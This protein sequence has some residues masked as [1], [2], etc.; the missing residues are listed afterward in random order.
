M[1]ANLLLTSMPLRSFEGK[2]VPWTD[3]ETALT[4]LDR[5]EPGRTV[6]ADFDETLFLRNSS[7]EFI[8][9]VKPYLFGVVLFKILEFLRPWSWF[10]RPRQ[11]VLTRDWFHV[12][13]VTLFFPWTWLLWRKNARKMADVWT[14]K[15]LLEVLARRDPGNVVICSQ[16]FGPVVRPVLRHMGLGACKVDTCGLLTGYRDR[17]RPKTRRVA[18]LAGE[19][20]LRKAAVVTDSADD[21]DILEAAGVPLLVEWP[22]SPII[23]VT[24][25]YIPFYYMV[26][27]K[28]KGLAPIVRET[29]SVDL[30]FLLLA[31]S[32]ISPLPL[33][34]AF[35]LFLFFIS[36][37]LVYE[38]GYMENDQIAHEH[39]KDPVFGDTFKE[40]INRINYREP[41]IWAAF[42]TVAG[43]SV[44]QK[45]HVLHGMGKTAPDLFGD[46]TLVL[47]TY[48]GLFL[49]QPHV[50]MAIIWMLVLVCLR[51]VYTAY[52]HTDKMTRTWIY[53]VLQA[54][55]TV[56]FMVIS[57]TN[58]V[59]VIALCSQAA[60]RSF[61]YFLYRWSKYD[62]PG[63]ELHVARL[64]LFVTGVLA[65][66]PA[67]GFSYA[68]LLTF[69]TLA[70]VSWIL[71]RARNGIIDLVKNIKHVS[72]D[73]WQR[74]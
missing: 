70:I 58:L 23:A 26:R 60:A 41:W 37:W 56:S 5:L 43:A 48:K 3:P 65:L 15:P 6:V 71:I 39:E 16:G 72:D 28:H 74:D 4:E 59:G 32:W 46:V 34:H 38:M 25:H 21:R 68:S 2:K 12:M 45:I 47:E 19:E 17:L 27:V 73:T 14:N 33:L 42:F 66:F 10:D 24:S 13:A 36:F 18:D 7:H 62:W 30:V 8:R 22:P 67:A 1:Y 52:N 61:A 57:A 50:L 11:A 53:P 29:F 69:Q 55:K 54:F 44:F 49:T 20:A 31:F 63:N 40:Q 64:V 51:L 9:M 35:G